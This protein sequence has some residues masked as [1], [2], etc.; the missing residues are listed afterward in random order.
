MNL[1]PALLSLALLS[2]LPV[3]AHAE[4]GFEVRDLA[5]LDR[6]S[7]PVLSPDGRKVVFAKRV[8]DF[9]ANKSATSLWIEDLFARDAAPPARL[10]PEGWNVNSPEYAA[11]GAHVYF[12]SAKSGSMQLYA[13]PVAGGAPVQLTDLPV[14]VGAF[15]VSPDGK[16]VALGRRGV[17]RLQGRPRMHGEARTRTR[18]PPR[19]RAR[20]S[21]TC[22]SATGM[23]GTKASSIACSSRPWA[24]RRSRRPRWSAA[25]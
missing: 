10:T 13:I 3:A 25:T 5:K 23:P 9:A 1:R 14:D 15:K 22:S 6:V 24:A 2:A 8:V 20:C 18:P 12:L 16:Q 17:C 19:R 21:T 11:D 4:R 7:S